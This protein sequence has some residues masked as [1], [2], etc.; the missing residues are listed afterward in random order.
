[1]HSLILSSCHYRFLGQLHG[2]WTKAITQGLTFRRGMHAKDIKLFVHHLTIFNNSILDLYFVSEV[3]WCNWSMYWWLRALAHWY[4]D[5]CCF[6]TSLGWVL[7]HLLPHPWPV[8]WYHPSPLAEPG[9]GQRESWRQSP[10]VGW[11]PGHQWG[12]AVAQ[13]L[14]L[15]KERWLSL[16][17]KNHHDR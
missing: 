16:A 10:V 2:W 11:N 13:P 6:S 9:C 12:P 5:S 15:P 7:C 1:M 17:N 8:T 4:A 3:W 14:I